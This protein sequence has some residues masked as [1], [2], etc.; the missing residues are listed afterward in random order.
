MELVKVRQVFPGR[1]V[2]VAMQNNLV[3]GC[4]VVDFDLNGLLKTLRVVDV[5]FLDDSTERL[6]VERD[7]YRDSISVS[8][9]CTHRHGACGVGVLQVCHPIFLHH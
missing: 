7:F 5:A 3:F 4:D 8:D 6:A 9:G 1:I 2:T